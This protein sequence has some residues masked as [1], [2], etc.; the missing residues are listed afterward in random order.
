MKQTLEGRYP[1]KSDVVIKMMTDWKFY[2]D[3]LDL[4]GI[5]GYEVVEHKFDG[6]KFSITL[7]RKITA[8]SVTSVETWDVAT[9]KGT[10]NVEVS[11]MP[12]KIACQTALKDD[13]KD[14]LLVYNW[15]VSSSVPLVG[16]RL[17]KQFAGENEKQLHTQTAFGVK[18]LKNY[19]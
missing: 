7:K 13:G 6:K 11:G 10:I 9:K 12:I 18:L 1:A 17:E 16:G 15:D 19:A 3:R 14:T 5:K 4:E 8:I 2:T